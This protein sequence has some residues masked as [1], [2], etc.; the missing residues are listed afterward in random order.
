MI[1]E[2]YYKLG[3]L[4][5]ESLHDTANAISIYEQFIQ[6]FT[7]NTHELEVWFA[8]YQLYDGQHDTSNVAKYKSLILSNYPDSDYA[9]VI[10][11]PDYFVKQ[12]EKKGQIV[13]LYNRTYKAFEREQY[14]RVLASANKA[15]EEYADNTTIIPRFLY[16]RAIALGKITTADSM[17]TEMKA[18]VT[19]FPQSEVTPLAKEILKTLR[20]EYGFDGGVNGNDK[21]A[22]K[23]VSKYKVGDNMPFLVILAVNGNKVKVNPLKIRLSDFNKKYFRLRKLS[24]KSLQL[25]N[26]RVLI[27]VGNFKNKDDAANY[28]N[29]LRNDEYVLSGLDKHDYS[30]FPISIENYPIMYRDKDVKG[31]MEFMDENLKLD[32]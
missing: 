29:A 5:K 16:L 27:Y 23:K 28:Y 32:E 10:I 19:K 8:L 9:K 13:K 31:Y 20:A 30:V 22:I 11:D 12:A 17:Y 4:Y 26:Q 24:I 18:L 2:A 3:S 6:R 15:I 14:F 7:G 25:D 21:E 1:I